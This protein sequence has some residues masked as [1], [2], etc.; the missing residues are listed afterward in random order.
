MVQG[1][2]PDRFRESLPSRV[3]WWVAQTTHVPA[4]FSI[5]MVAGAYPTAT[6]TNKW[7]MVPF[8][9]TL[10]ADGGT[11]LV[12]GIVETMTLGMKTSLGVTVDPA[13]GS[14]WGS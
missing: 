10:T 1:T 6:K 5:E 3:D 8:T 4:P 12:G 13:M 7:A 2:H 9:A 14:R 11:V